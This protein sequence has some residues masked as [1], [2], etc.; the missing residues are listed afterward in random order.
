MSG[1]IDIKTTQVVYRSPIYRLGTPN[2]AI[3]KEF[4]PDGREIRG[5]GASI[6]SEDKALDLAVENVKENARDV[7][8]SFEISVIKGGGDGRTD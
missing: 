6:L 7:D 1:D 3:A 2:V 4:T 5:I 8:F